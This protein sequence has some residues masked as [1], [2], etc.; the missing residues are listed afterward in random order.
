MNGYQYKSE[1]SVLDLERDIKP[2]DIPNGAVLRGPA[3]EALLVDYDDDGKMLDSGTEVTIGKWMPGIGKTIPED[4]IILVHSVKGEEQMLLRSLEVNRLLRD[5]IPLK[6]KIA[7][8][9][10][11]LPQFVETLREKY[12]EGLKEKQCESTVEDTD[13]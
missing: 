1:A 5:G 9:E 2:T 11:I 10:G 8:R 4:M 3:D 7:A 6:V 13:G 12:M